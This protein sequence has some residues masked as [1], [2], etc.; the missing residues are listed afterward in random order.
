MINYKMLVLDLDDTLLKS[1]RT[2]SES[3][4]EHLLRAQKKWN[5]NCS[6]LRQTHLWNKK[7][8]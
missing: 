1:D 4:K 8:C 7:N 6:C 5:N 2:I 3:T